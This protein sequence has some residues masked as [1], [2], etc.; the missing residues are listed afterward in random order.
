VYEETDSTSGSYS[1]LQFKGDLD[2]KIFSQKSELL[3]SL[4]DGYQK[5]MTYKSSGWTLRACFRAGEVNREF[6]RFLVES[7]VPAELGEAQ[8]QEYRTLLGQKADAYREKAEEYFRACLEL[9]GKSEICD[10]VLAGYFLP[11][12]A[13]TGNETSFSSLSTVRTCNE[14][15][16]RGL[17]NERLMGLYEEL[18]ASPDDGL[19]QLSL[20]KA[21]LENGDY[22]QAVLIAQNALSKLDDAKGGVPAALLNLIGVAKLNSGEDTEARDAFRQAISAHDDATEARINLAS[23]LRHYGHREKAVE[24]LDGI[25]PASLSD[26]NVIHP[27][28][29]AIFDEY[30]MRTR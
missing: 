21:Y 20:A 25:G 10:P 22:R 14:I 27:Q 2:N 18:L 19:L 8:K 28:A 4:E 3:T 23:L 17:S 26:D 12:G 6:A 15:G 9:A 29:G 30:A 13:P 24:L 5:V 1:A 16:R 7:P 11:T